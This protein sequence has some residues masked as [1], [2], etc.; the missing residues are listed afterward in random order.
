MLKFYIKILNMLNLYFLF[1]IIITLTTFVQCNNDSNKTWSLNLY[2]SLSSSHKIA[3]YNITLINSNYYKQK[4]N[5]DITIIFHF[6]DLVIS[7]YAFDNS[8]VF[9]DV[10]DSYYISQYISY[11]SNT[12]ALLIN[13]IILSN[14]T[15]LELLTDTPVFTLSNKSYNELYT[16]TTT[17]YYANISFPLSSMSLTEMILIIINISLSVLISIFIKGMYIYN[18]KCKQ[19]TEILE[20]LILNKLPYANLILSLFIVVYYNTFEYTYDNN[21]LMLLLFEHMYVVL[22]CL[23]RATIIITSFYFLSGWLIFSFNKTVIKIDKYIFICFM[24]DF[25]YELIILTIYDNKQIKYKWIYW[26]NV[27]AYVCL[28]GVDLYYF[29]KL[30]MKIYFKVNKA[31]LFMQHEVVKVLKYKMN[32]YKKIS[33]SCFCYC[34]IKWGV[35]LGFSNV[36]KGCCYMSFELLADSVCVGVVLFVFVPRKWPGCY[37]LEVNLDFVGMQDFVCNV[38]KGNVKNVKEA[39]K[40]MVKMLKKNRPV[41]IIGP[42]G[43]SERKENVVSINDDNVKEVNDNGV[44]DEIKIGVFVDE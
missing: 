8:I 18:I 23:I 30:Y 36:E 21:N 29:V 14:N 19:N 10:N 15:F 11:Y 39:K 26:K 20:Y 17:Y 24:V 32:I 43:K 28:F 13:D 31:L 40:E 12:Y 2:S 33:L 16:I 3:T 34:L 38:N 27:I 5:Y 6:S 37:F 7:P 41:L 42:F 25:I 9:F 44:F 1:T 22:V 35:P 4:S